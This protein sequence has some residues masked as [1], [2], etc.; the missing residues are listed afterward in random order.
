MQTHSLVEDMMQTYSLVEVMKQTN[1]LVQISRQLQG[2]QNLR[3]LQVQQI[4]RH[5]WDSSL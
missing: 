2:Q 1:S 3:H 4:S 5:C